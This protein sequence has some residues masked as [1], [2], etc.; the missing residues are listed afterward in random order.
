MYRVEYNLLSSYASFPT[1]SIRLQ[2]ISTHFIHG[3]HGAQF[4]VQDI[5]D[6]LSSLVFISLLGRF[7]LCTSLELMSGAFFI[8]IYDSSQAQSLLYAL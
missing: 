3:Y 6:A 8:P 7:D 4:R 5:S 1:T 2:K